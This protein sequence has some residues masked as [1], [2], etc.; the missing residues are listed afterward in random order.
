M[1]RERKIW[2]LSNSSKKRSLTLKPESKVKE[3]FQECVLTVWNTLRGFWVVL[4]YLIVCLFDDKPWWTDTSI[5]QI[6]SLLNLTKDFFVKIV[7]FCENQS[8]TVHFGM[9]KYHGSKFDTSRNWDSCKIET[10]CPLTELSFKKSLSS[11]YYVVISAIH[12]NI[13]PLHH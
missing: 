8:I 12:L 13:V 9:V 4:L 1:T 7:F 5:G 3:V 10:I 6:I 2:G 11:F